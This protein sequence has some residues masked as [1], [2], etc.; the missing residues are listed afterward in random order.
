M[1]HYLVK[2]SP[3][4]GDLYVV[5]SDN[6]DSPLAFG[7]RADLTEWFTRRGKPEQA[8]PARFDRADATGTSALWPDAAAPYLRFGKGMIYEQ[9]GWLPRE[10]LTALCERLAVDEDDRVVDLLE[11]FDGETEVRP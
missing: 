1:S 9:R 5:W 3:D 11:P 8:E 6:S 7:S 10:N 4:S 2:P